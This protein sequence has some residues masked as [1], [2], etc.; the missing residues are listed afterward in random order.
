ME[1]NYKG[2]LLELL[3]KFHGIGTAQFTHEPNDIQF[4]AQLNVVLEYKGDKKEYTACSAGSFPTKKK[5]EQSATCELLNK[6][7]FLLH[8]NHTS[9][10][11]NQD[12][13]VEDLCS[14]FETIA[15]NVPV[16]KNF[17]GILYEK[18]AQLKGKVYFATSTDPNFPTMFIS[19]VSVVMPGNNEP[20]L[21]RSNGVF[22][23]K[24]MAEQSAAEQMLPVL[25]DMLFKQVPL[26][27]N[28]STSIMHISNSV[29]PKHTTELQSVNAQGALTSQDI[30]AGHIDTS[31]PHNMWETN[32]RGR[33]LEVVQK[34]GP[35][36]ALH[37]ATT[38]Q[39]PFVCTVTL[40]C[41]LSSVT[42]TT[43][44]DQNAHVQHVQEITV[45]SQGCPTKK[46]AER[47]ASLAMRDD[48]RFA[49]ILAGIGEQDK[50]QSA[51]G[52]KD[53]S[54]LCG[55]C[56]GVVGDT[57]DFAFFEDVDTVFGVKPEAPLESLQLKLRSDSADIDNVH[58]LHCGV[59]L[60]RTRAFPVSSL[61]SCSGSLVCF[62]RDSLYVKARRCSEPW[63]IVAVE[64]VF[65]NVE[66]RSQANNSRNTLQS[67]ARPSWRTYCN[68]PIV[69]P[70][71]KSGSSSDISDLISAG[72]NKIP[73]PQQLQALEL[74]LKEHMI[75]VFPTGFGKT[76]VASMFMHRF[77][78]LNPRKLAVLVVDRV[79]LVQQQCQAIHQDTGLA[80]C[81]LSG[82]NGK[83]YVVRQLVRGKY[84]ALVVTVGAL[85]NHL[86]RD[87]LRVS[88]FSAIV[89]D[90]CHHVTGEHQY[91]KLLEL[92]SRCPEHLRP[93]FLG[94]TASPFNAKDEC[95][96]E[97]K[98]RALQAACLGAKFYRPVL[99][100]TGYSEG[101]ERIAVT[102]SSSQLAMQSDIVEK[103]SPVVE[104]LCSVYALYNSELSRASA[105]INVA[106]KDHW[107]MIGNLAAEAHLGSLPEA[108]KERTAGLSKTARVLVRALQSNYLL[109]PAFVT[110]E[111]S[112][113]EATLSCATVGPDGG[114]ADVD[115]GK[116][117]LSNQL[118]EL[119][120]VLAECGAQSSTL[121][122]VE[123]RQTAEVL[124][125]YLAARFPALNCAKLI[126]QGG[127]DGMNWRGEA[128][129][130]AVLQSFRSGDTKLIVCTS[131]LEEG[132]WCSIL[133][134]TMEI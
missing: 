56:A 43:D 84:A 1:N 83:S 132:V 18:V 88:D 98:L 124:V 46:L 105:C 55:S 118:Q 92:M 31:D 131:V 112:N 128:G 9:L 80:V 123:T 133:N 99:N 114:A 16:V 34:L 42:S 108:L 122:F 20:I 45:A 73:R 89:L 24:T 129:Q 127:V 12:S 62:D 40:T 72:C 54:V 49:A 53:P 59:V 117:G 26:V 38:T 15:I 51:G 74:A 81:P 120:S 23:K 52:G 13:I 21:C 67:P 57:S 134:I 68:I 85:C 5:A 106:C 19:V 65:S 107:C 70:D 58:C 82:E 101:T 87:E 10:E 50:T 32:A 4:S 71:A 3:A 35:G 110:L 77:Y 96:A 125:G 8:V 116:A 11:S 44:R 6:K 90:E 130:G 27:H 93:R 29:E 2:T 97:A 111:E 126:G 119:C 75:V 60:G 61:P 39:A 104:E 95:S 115:V 48:E 86:D 30:S 41:P 17:K 28:P 69:L 14:Q 64:S 76:F 37:Y 47:L 22:S 63:G 94:L 121:V 109:G 78:L 33:L 103:L 91:K 113:P 36:C 79:P 25:G 66:R 7:D 100:C 102:L